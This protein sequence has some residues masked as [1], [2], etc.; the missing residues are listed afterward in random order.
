MG[1]LL[2]IVNAVYAGD[3]KIV[4]EFSNGETRLLDFSQLVS[5]GK[6]LCQLLV[7]KSYFRNFKLDPFTIDWNDEI[8]FDPDF[9]YEMSKPCP[10]YQFPVGESNG[11]VAEDVHC[12]RE[13]R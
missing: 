7:D 2:T 9:L 6:G 10:K 11:L 4:A 8:G 1:E 13:N 3:Y 5:S 12:N